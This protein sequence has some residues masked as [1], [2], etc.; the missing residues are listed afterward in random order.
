MNSEGREVQRTG[1]FDL[2][3]LCAASTLSVS[4]EE[5]KR[6]GEIRGRH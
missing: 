1:R 5:G 2:S 4:E 6:E 3:Q